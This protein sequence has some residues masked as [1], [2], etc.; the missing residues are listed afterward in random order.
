MDDTERATMSYPYE[1]LQNHLQC[2][3]EWN[4]EVLCKGI[5]I[6]SPSNIMVYNICD[7]VNPITTNIKPQEASITGS[8]PLYSQMKPFLDV[9]SNFPQFD[10]PSEFKGVECRASIKSYIA[11]KCRELV[12]NV[13]T[14]RE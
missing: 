8:N 7:F 4:C 9:S 1:T 13:I 12:L 10:P 2:M 11:Q 3:S 6:T 14:I 5:F